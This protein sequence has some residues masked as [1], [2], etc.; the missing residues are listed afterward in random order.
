MTS[1][2]WTEAGAPREVRTE[3]PGAVLRDLLA[4][5]VSGDVPGLT[6]TRPS[7]EDVYLRLVGAASTATEGEL[8]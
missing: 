8:R 5:S 1:V 3:S 4:G 2:R 6:I 7:L